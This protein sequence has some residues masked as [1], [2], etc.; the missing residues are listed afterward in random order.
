[1]IFLFNS[2][3]KFSRLILM[4]PL[5]L[6]QTQDIL[7]QVVGADLAGQVSDIGVWAEAA[8][9]FPNKYSAVTYLGGNQLQKLN[10]T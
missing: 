7:I 9:F 2:N 6:Q 8:I 1:M 10:C 3:K 5:I 4:E